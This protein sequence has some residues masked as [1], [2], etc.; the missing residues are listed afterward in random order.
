MWC[1]LHKKIFFYRNILN[2]DTTANKIL[3]TKIFIMF[4]DDEKYMKRLFEY[5]LDI[6]DHFIDVGKLF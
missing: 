6:R 4:S 3:A 2:K 5:A 1:C